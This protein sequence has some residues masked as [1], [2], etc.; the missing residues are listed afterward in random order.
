MV[1]SQLLLDTKGLLSTEL[2]AGLTA[3][4]Q[5]WPLGFCRYL[6]QAPRVLAHS[7]SDGKIFLKVDPPIQG[8]D[9]NLFPKTPTE[10]DR[11]WTLYPL[12]KFRLYLF[13]LKPM[14]VHGKSKHL[15]KAGVSVLVNKLH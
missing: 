9:T 5:R 10:F 7:T 13:D 2:E 8:R 6:L 1:I 11:N 15:W 4:G 14:G 3:P 12:L